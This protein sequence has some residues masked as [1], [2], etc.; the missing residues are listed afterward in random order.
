MWHHRLVW[1][2]ETSSFCDT[3]ESKGIS[4]LVEK[5]WE[6]YG[7]LFLFPPFHSVSMML[8]LPAL[9]FSRFPCSISLLFLA[10]PCFSALLL[11]L[12]SSFL[13][14]PSPFFLPLT[15]CLFQSYIVGFQRFTDIVTLNKTGTT[16]PY[17]PSSKLLTLEGSPSTFWDVH[18]PHRVPTPEL[19]QR[20]QPASRHIVMFREPVERLY[21]DFIYFNSDLPR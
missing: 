8:L 7:T 16:A 13:F 1:K 6:I 14:L 20:L 19:L 21:S 2:V 3:S 12:L 5:N 11:F 18:G 15:C 9:L 4:L 17:L 10:L